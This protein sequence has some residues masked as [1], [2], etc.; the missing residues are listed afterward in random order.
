MRARTPWD[1]GWLTGELEAINVS[2]TD[3]TE[4]NGSG[5][6][7]AADDVDRVQARLLTARQQAAA[8]AAQIEYLETELTHTAR[9]LLNRRWDTASAFLAG[10]ILGA[11]GLA[12]VLYLSVP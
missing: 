12:A 1:Q 5:M 11:I 2:L 6:T 7:R 4:P 10:L 9:R 8:Q 3:P